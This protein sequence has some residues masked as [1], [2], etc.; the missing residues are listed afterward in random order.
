MS[1]APALAIGS[2][3]TLLG[4]LLCRL[5]AGTGY[6]SLAG[7]SLD[8]VVPATVF[9]LLA[10]ISMRPIFAGMVACALS[11]GFA[12]ADYSKR[13]SLGEPVLVTDFIATYDILRHPKLCL[14]FPRPLLLGVG[15]MVAG[16][17][18]VMAFVLETPTLQLSWLARVAV[19]GTAAMV[20]W[21]IANPLLDVAAACFERFK[22]AGR[23]RADARM[24]GP[25]AML[26]VYAVLARAQRALLQTSARMRERQSNAPPAFS[27]SP[28]VVIQCESFF[29]ARRLHAG[30]P[31]DLLSTFDM[32][33][34]D[35]L[36]WGRLSAPAWGA[37]T[38]RTEFATLTGIPARG[39]GYDRFN[40]YHR[41]ARTPIASLPW[42][43]KSQGYRTIC[44]HPF[45]RTFY[46]R[47][48]VLAHLGFDDFLGE[49]AFPTGMRQNRFVEDVA[50]AR[51]IAKLLDAYGPKTFVFAITMENHGPW[52]DKVGSDRDLAPTLPA[53]RNRDVLN[54]YLRGIAGADAMLALLTGTL[55]ARGD[56]GILA[57]YGDHLPN[58]PSIFAEFGFRNRRSDYLLWSAFGG[59]GL[60]KDLA[61]HEL[62]G[63][64][65]QARE[66]T[67]SSMPDALRRPDGLPR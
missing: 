6:R 1:L 10:V 36:Q 13:K 65:S 17:I 48:K 41:F 11:A 7:A 5:E 12:T 32:C 44:V 34:R 25:F 2:T 30:I 61:A 21:L 18:V 50:V 9:L 35:A 46:G 47:H 52:D 60:R 26:T 33:R 39:V 16:S 51:L 31:S 54:A 45:D 58:L 20:A 29:D 64:I 14:I 24:I 19:I 27:P 40:P 42:Q 22:L 37:N 63:D 38:V 57:F 28:L 62:A 15:I 23:P 59:S 66:A 53:V 43:L 49:D 56:G 8:A 67:R 4:W 55:R 3:L